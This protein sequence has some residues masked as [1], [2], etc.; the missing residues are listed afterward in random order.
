VSLVCVVHDVV[1]QADAKD[2][3]GVRSWAAKFAPSI[4]SEIPLQ[5][6]AFRVI[7][8][9]VTTGAA[10]CDAQAEH[11]RNAILHG[12]ENVTW[13]SSCMRRAPSK[14]K[15]IFAVSKSATFGGKRAE[16][17]EPLPAGAMNVSAEAEIQDVDAAIVLL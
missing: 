7:P 4:V 15:V 1:E 10:I 6:G 3:V 5:I 17:S 2:T 13:A 14:L 12:K 8:P 9:T 16:L 11:E